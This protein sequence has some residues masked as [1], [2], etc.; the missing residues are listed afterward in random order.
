MTHKPMAIAAWVLLSGGC[1]APARSVDVRASM[2]SGAL[3]RASSCLA[4]SFDEL[5]AAA[6]GMRPLGP[7]APGMEG[8]AY[9]VRV[10]RLEEGEL[11]DSVER[12]VRGVFEPDPN[13]PAF[14]VELEAARD[15]ARVERAMTLDASEATRPGERAA[16]R[17]FAAAVA[18]CA[19][20]ALDVYT[21]NAGYADAVGEAMHGVALVDAFTREVLWFHVIESWA[22]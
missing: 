20:P 2:E 19:A 15:V 4:E 14:Y 16:R 11:R 8:R 5:R 12:R 3:E 10:F 9:A 18:R 6:P 17:A 1:G 13:D 7:D 21:L 22:P